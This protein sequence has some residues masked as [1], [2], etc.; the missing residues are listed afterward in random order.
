MDQRSE[1]SNLPEGTQLVI[2]ITV[3]LTKF[4]ESTFCVIVRANNGRGLE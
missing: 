2:S 4:F 1:M 3:E